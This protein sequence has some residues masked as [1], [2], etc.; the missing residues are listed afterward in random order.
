MF[1]ITC[2]HTLQYRVCTDPLPVY[3]TSCR[4][5]D[6]RA[7]RTAKRIALQSGRVSRSPPAY[8]VFRTSTELPVTTDVITLSI[9]WWFNCHACYAIVTS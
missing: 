3:T 1:T 6:T 2:M 9:T 4:R 7:V 5:P 8:T